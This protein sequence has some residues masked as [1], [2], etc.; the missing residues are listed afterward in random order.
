MQ[1]DSDLP[2]IEEKYTGNYLN[3]TVG[4]PSYHHLAARVNLAS[5][6]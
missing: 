3:E 5:A 2:S 6:R 1:D 4:Q